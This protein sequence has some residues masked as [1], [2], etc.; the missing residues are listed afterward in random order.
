MK[1]PDAKAAV[2]PKW[3]KLGKMSAWQII[4]VE[5]KK[6]VIREAQKEQRTVHFA[7]L[8]DTCHLKSAEARIL[9][10]HST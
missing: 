5:S 8:M 7:A 2:D 6:E 3:E 4:K 10:M 1:I 9:G